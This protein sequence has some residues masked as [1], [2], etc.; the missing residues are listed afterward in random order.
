MLVM[1]AGFGLGVL[2]YVLTVQCGNW[3]I[4]SR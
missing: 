3:F 4:E 1:L 2:T